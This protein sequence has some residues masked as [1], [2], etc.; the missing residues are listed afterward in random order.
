MLSVCS[1]WAFTQRNI[2]RLLHHLPTGKFSCAQLLTLTMLCSLNVQ[3]N[4]RSIRVFCLNKLQNTTFHSLL[5]ANSCT[6]AVIWRTCVF[7][8]LCHYHFSWSRQC[9]WWLPMSKTLCK[10]TIW[11]RQADGSTTPAHSSLC[12]LHLTCTT[13]TR[14]LSTCKE[15][16][17]KQ[18][19]LCPQYIPAY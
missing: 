13:E 9:E 11:R 2:S 15:R 6:L 5:Y 3:S 4:C 10:Y 17:T 12:S 8:N 14:R 7:V 1:N 19:T 16:L 18:H